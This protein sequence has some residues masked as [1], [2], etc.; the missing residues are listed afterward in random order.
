MRLKN[1][2]FIITLTAFLTESA[3]AKE[4]P[5][6]PDP[7]FLEFLGTFEEDEEKNI[8]PLDLAELPG[9][10]KATVKSRP[11][12]SG[13]EKEKTEGKGNQR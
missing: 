12:K 8:D 5:Q 11:K 10:M 7:E 6:A 13:E 2:I 3:G 4:V 9:D 1:F